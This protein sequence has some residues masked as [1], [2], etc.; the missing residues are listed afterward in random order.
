MSILD[1]LPPTRAPEIKGARKIKRMGLTPTEAERLPTPESAREYNRRY[2]RKHRV[3]IL[4][5][6]S[7]ARRRKTGRA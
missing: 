7:E 6:Q 1:V 3:R 2:Y 5:R 4:R